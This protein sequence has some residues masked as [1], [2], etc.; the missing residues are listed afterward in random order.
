MCLG[1]ANEGEGRRREAPAGYG[2]QRDLARHV[3]FDDLPRLD[4]GNGD[5]TLPGEAQAESTGNHRLDPVLALAA[6]NDRRPDL[7]LAA[8]RADMIVILAIG[9]RDHRLALDLFERHG[10]ELAEAMPRRKH[11]DIAI[12]I[13]RPRVEALTQRLGSGEQCEIDV[14]LEDHGA[15]VARQGLANRDLDAGMLAAEGPEEADQLERADRAH[16]A[17][18]QGRLLELQEALRRGLRRACL[19]QHK[20][21]MRLHEASEIGDV[22]EAAL[23]PEEQAAE[24]LFE[25]LNRA[26][27]RGLGDMTLLGGTCEIQRVA[28]GEEITDLVHLHSGPRCGC[29]FASN[30]AALVPSS[31]GR[32][33]GSARGGTD[34]DASRS[35]PIAHDRRGN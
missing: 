10:I 5:G 11:H 30:S 31:C 9:A 12:T 33:G 19:A 26:S 4:A 17:E 21:Q 23:A 34:P 2:Y 24:L 6:V 29:A 13:D 25:L 18:I 14:S 22:G 3:R 15:E 1:S 16:D 27:Q 35:Y 7:A 28:D 20:G 32:G 8:D